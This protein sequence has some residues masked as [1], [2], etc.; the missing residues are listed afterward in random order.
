MT[1][2]LGISSNRQSETPGESNVSRM[3]ACRNIFQE[4]ILLI[5][6]SA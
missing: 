6:I 1:Q 3:P 4:L 5:Q 2:Q